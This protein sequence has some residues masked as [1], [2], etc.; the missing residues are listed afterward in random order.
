MNITSAPQSNV[1]APAGRSNALR[2]IAGFT[3]IETLL[4]ITLMSIVAGLSIP[5]FYGAYQRQ[6]MLNTANEMISAIKFARAKALA[7]DQGVYKVDPPIHDCDSAHPY[8][9]KYRF[10]IDAD[11]KGY[12]VTPSLRATAGCATSPAPSS[13]LTRKLP[14]RVIVNNVGGSASFPI[15]YTNVS[16]AFSVAPGELA[17]IELLS[18]GGVLSNAKYYICIT[19][20]DLYAQPNACS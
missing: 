2:A 7:N 15:S 18:S 5:F 3:L 16:G 12:A 4:A 6:E 1:P 17:W 19:P 13:V 8:I 9:D 10:S 11:K 14:E 20:N